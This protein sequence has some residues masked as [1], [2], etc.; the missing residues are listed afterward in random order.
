MALSAIGVHLI[1]TVMFFG[2]HSVLRAHF[3][4]EIR[5]PEDVRWF[6]CN[7]TMFRQFRLVKK[8]AGSHKGIISATALPGKALCHCIGPCLSLGSLWLLQPRL[9]SRRR[10]VRDRNPIRRHLGIA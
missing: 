4:F 6:L 1:G 5:T 8:R 3:D 2:A 10:L 7:G 9:Q